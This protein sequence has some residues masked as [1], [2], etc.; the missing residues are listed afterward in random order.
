MQIIVDL[1]V[2][3][4][5]G[6]GHGATLRDTTLVSPRPRAEA[7]GWA[8][9]TGPPGYSANA[10]IAPVTSRLRGSGRPADA[11]R[12]NRPCYH[13]NQARSHFGGSGS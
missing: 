13:E 8:N 3:P 6:S 4:F 12:P 11:P 10:R 9:R 7:H 5:R 1:A 2:D